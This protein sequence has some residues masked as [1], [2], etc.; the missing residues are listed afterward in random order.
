MEGS[1]TGRSGLKWAGI[2]PDQIKSIKSLL[3]ENGLLRVRINVKNSN[4]S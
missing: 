4:I 1:K 3:R 2:K